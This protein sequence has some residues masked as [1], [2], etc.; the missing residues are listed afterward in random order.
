MNKTEL[1]NK[2]IELQKASVANLEE[3]INTTH[4]MVDV[5][6]SDT[7]D[8]EDL[9]HQSESAESEHIFKQQ[10]SK[11]KIDHRLRVAKKK[12]RENLDSAH[13][14]GDRG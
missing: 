5:D 14:G 12:L 11:A 10:L 8:P 9:S 1:K 6:E 2:L 13:K 3:K 4:S 7:I